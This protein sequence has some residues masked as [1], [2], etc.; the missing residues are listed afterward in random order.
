MTPQAE[1]P[2]CEIAVGADQNVRE[3]ARTDSS[4]VF[5]PTD[6][7]V[8]G[9]CLVIPT[10][11][12][13]TFT[14]LRPDE[15]Q[16]IMSTA[17]SV[18]KSITLAFQPQGIN[19]IQSNGKTASQTIP[20]VHVHV[21]PR[22]NG[23]RIGALWPSKSNFSKQE[24]DHA[25]TKIQALTSL[26]SNAVSPEDRRQHLIFIQDIISRMAHSSAATKGWLL[27]VATAAYGYSFTKESFPVAILGIV[28]TCIFFFLDIGYLRTE[29][30]YRR[31][32]NRVITGA[33]PTVSSYS[34]DYHETGDNWKKTARDCLQV[35]SGWAVGPFYIALMTVGIIAALITAS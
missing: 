19:I 4:V 10:R 16:A 32:Y 5:F 8:L 1:C 23:D 31:L 14:E 3:V 17:Q 18:A 7:A 29:R 12:V 9:H 20:H 34:L 11:H 35:A 27:P 15:L 2:F 22:W 13:E 25:L 28:A 21:V 26:N 6:P 30:K 24:K 33:S